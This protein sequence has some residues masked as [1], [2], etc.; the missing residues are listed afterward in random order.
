[1]SQRTGNRGRADEAGQPAET[2]DGVMAA[3]AAAAGLL[4]GWA[5]SRHTARLLAAPPYTSP[6]RSP[7]GGT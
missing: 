5:A 3:A 1:M 6:G 7:G 4:A 2:A